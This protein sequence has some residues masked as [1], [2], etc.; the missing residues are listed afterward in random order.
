MIFGLPQNFVMFKAETREGESS[1]IFG[2][3]KP[4]L[5]MGEGDAMGEL[6]TALLHS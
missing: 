5:F 4:P 1:K 3:F 6:S 2:S